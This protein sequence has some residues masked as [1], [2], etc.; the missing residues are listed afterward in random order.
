MKKGGAIAGS[1]LYRHLDQNDIRLFLLLAR[2][3]HLHHTSGRAGVA[4]VISC[5]DVPGDDITHTARIQ[6][7]NGIAFNFDDTGFRLVHLFSAGI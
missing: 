3:Y 7:G 1:A 5:N 4:T 2:F 6:D